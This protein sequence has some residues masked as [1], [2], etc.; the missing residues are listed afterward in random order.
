MVDTKKTYDGKVGSF[1]KT[2]LGA[3]QTGSVS[4]ALAQSLD[5][6]LVKLA[7][8]S[9]PP[10]MQRLLR[11]PAFSSLILQGH[12][13]SWDPANQIVPIIDL[14][15]PQ[16]LS[17]LLV[18]KPA[19][20]GGSD[21][22]PVTIYEC[23]PGGEVPF[24]F[25]SVVS[26]YAQGWDSI[27]NDRQLFFFGVH[28]Q[29]FPPTGHI[30]DWKPTSATTSKFRVWKYQPVTTGKKDGNPLRGTPINKKGDDDDWST[31]GSDFRLLYLPSEIATEKD[32]VLVW[33]TTGEFWVWE[34][35]ISSD[36]PLPNPPKQ[37]GTWTID[38]RPK[39]LVYLGENQI[40]EWSPD[41]HYKVWTYDRT[42]PDPMPFQ[43]ASGQIIRDRHSQDVQLAYL[44]KNRVMLWNASTGGFAIHHFIFR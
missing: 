10:V 39:N 12:V 3:D 9:Q 41:T 43:I 1:D 31:I 15:S 40:V 17:Q 2:K 14:A 44:G 30:L 26:I 29:T 16:L 7:E 38:K 42:G 8:K 24:P 22:S 13:P 34:Y 4:S 27:Q 20:A 23:A 6:T 19:A 25:K 28:G 33:N 35:D 32:R 37:S 36:D 11:N 21:R 5:K 18:W